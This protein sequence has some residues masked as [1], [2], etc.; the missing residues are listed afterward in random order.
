MQKAVVYNNF[1]FLLVLHSTPLKY[2]TE[3]ESKNS[4]SHNKEGLKT[5]LASVSKYIMKEAI[6]WVIHR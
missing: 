3:S 2:Q 5:L 6:I 4:S 1:D